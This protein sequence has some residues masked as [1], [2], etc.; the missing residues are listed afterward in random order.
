MDLFGRKEI[1]A[2]EQKIDALADKV[3]VEKKGFK[4]GDNSTN[5]Y[6]KALTKHIQNSVTL[7]DFS[8]VDRTKLVNYYRTNAIVRGII[9][10][11][12]GGA[13]SELADYIE[14]IGKDGKQI[15]KHWAL[16]LLNKPNDM[17]NK[18]RFLK[19]W[20]INRNITGDAF[21]YGL[22]GVGTSA[23]QFT[24]LYLIPSQDVSILM[25]G[26]EQPIQGF[27]LPN[28]YTI[29]PELL[30]SEVMFSRE[31]DPQSTTYYGLSPLKSAIYVVQL[32]EKG[33]KRQNAALENGGV[34]VV[35]TPKSDQYGGVTE[36]QAENAE[37][38]LNNTSKS[39]FNKFLR[40]PVEVHKIGDTPADLALLETSKYAINALCFVYG[41][42]VDTFL[43]QSKYENAKEAKKAV[44]E[45]AAIPILNEFLE[46]FTAFCGL[47]GEKFILNTDKIDILK[48]STTETLTNLNSMGAS[49][50]E[51]RQY[52]GYEKINEPYCNLPM[53]PLGV[54][55]GDPNAFEVS[56]NES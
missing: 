11:T 17:F 45:Q 31:Y 32:L 26:A 6:L 44:Y 15:E 41:I 38:E 50:N 46:D 40:T 29:G 22:K 34:N 20:S 43:A 52:M 35:I 10:T 7:L 39:N 23:K 47:E 27:K 36:V 12:I 30:P 21:V 42:S 2:L 48:D 53:I 16:D 49:I 19:A 24:E 9:G 3:A 37:Q 25:G 55:L 28:S 56:E 1:K 8:D 18:R 13:V 51:K 4:G 14:L 33:D 54:S 5:K